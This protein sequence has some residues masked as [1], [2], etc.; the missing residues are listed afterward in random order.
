MASP[1]TM[2]ADS[3]P[4]IRP[5][6][7]MWPQYNRRLRDV[8]AGMTDEQLAVRP[9]PE[10]WP[11]WATVGHT[12]GARVYWLCGVIGEPGAETTPFPGAASGIGWEDDLQHP[13]SAAELV[14]ALDSTLRLVESCLD[15]W[16][17]EMLADQIHRDYD[18]TT[19]LHHRGSI[20]QRLFSHD[21]YHCGELSQTLGIHRLPQIDLWRP[22]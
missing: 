17:A 3:M 18:G 19:Q 12:A 8:I 2:S 22:D 21:A 6:Y 10:R 7:D 11:I 14:E 1:S 16:T 4:T 9:S 15:R 20:L 13:R 5:F